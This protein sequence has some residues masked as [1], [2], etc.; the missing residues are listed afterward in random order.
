MYHFIELLK[1]VRAPR[2]QAR[3]TKV[4]RESDQIV[5]PGSFTRIG[6]HGLEEEP[7]TL[8][9]VPSLSTKLVVLAVI[10]LLLPASGLLLGL[11]LSNVSL[12]WL[13]AGAGTLLS[14]LVGYIFRSDIQLYPLDLSH[15]RPHV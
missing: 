10:E 12:W 4:S 14:V 3:A 13:L 9:R 7:G 6:K 1:Q 15:R 11:Q 2:N 5:A 8:Q